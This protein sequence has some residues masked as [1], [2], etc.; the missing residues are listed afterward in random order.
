MVR[1]QVLAFVLLALAARGAAAQPAASRLDPILL[2]RARD[3]RGISRVI[4]QTA[5]PVAALDALVSAG[6]LPTLPLATGFAADVPDAALLWLADRPEVGSIGIDRPVQGTAAQ[7]A[8]T[9][10]AR[11][12]QD[13]LGYDGS[14]IGVATIDSG[15]AAWH[16]DLGAARVVHFADFVNHQTSAYD[17]FGHGTHVAGIIAGSGYDSGGLRRGLAPGASLVVL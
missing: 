2:E 15:V 10:G 12:V 13:T 3:P 16:D 1:R 17:D 11:W 5:S 14:G 9:I 6:G 8:S 7:V 4:V